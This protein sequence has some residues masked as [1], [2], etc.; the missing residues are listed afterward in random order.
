VV[1][2]PWNGHILAMVSLPSYNANLMTG[3]Q[4]EKAYPRLMN[5]RRHPFVD[6]SLE[7]QY[8][9]GSIYKIVTATAGLATGTISPSTTV[10]DTGKVQKVAGPT[11]FYGWYRPGL[12]PVDVV[13]AIA[14]SSDI[15]FYETAGG[16]PQI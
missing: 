5:N 16:G 9:P 14:E 3:P 11:L 6:N 1:M 7:G 4:R 10:D 2:N 8:P 12:G 15:F 13:H